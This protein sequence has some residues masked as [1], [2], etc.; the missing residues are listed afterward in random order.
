MRIEFIDEETVQ[1]FFFGRITI[2]ACQQ[3]SAV[4]LLDQLPADNKFIPGGQ[5]DIG[6]FYSFISIDHH[7]VLL[8]NKTFSF[9][10]AHLCFLK[11][12]SKQD[13]LIVGGVLNILQ[14]EFVVVKGKIDD[15]ILF[16]FQ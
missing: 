12:L 16:Y 9:L 13:D 4:F 6:F 11:L 1:V 15:G 8:E 5:C 14:T 3:H 10:F 7:H 2:K